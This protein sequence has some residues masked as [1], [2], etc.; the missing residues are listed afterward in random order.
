VHKRMVWVTLLLMQIW[1]ITP[2][3]L[4]IEVLDSLFEY[5]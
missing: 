4:N 1:N 5:L 3:K 2:G